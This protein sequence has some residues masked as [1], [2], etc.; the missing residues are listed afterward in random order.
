MIKLYKLIF[1]TPLSHA[2]IVRTAIG[3][4]G[5]GQVGNYSHCSFSIHGTGRFTPN[6]HATPH[7]G[8][9]NH[10]EMVEEEQIQV[11]VTSDKLKSVLDAL[12]ATHPYEEI[13]FELYEQIDWANL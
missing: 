13:G 2:D 8:Q 4:A 10:P 7:I 12:H 3:D 11:N 1:N 5:A 6:A 9:R